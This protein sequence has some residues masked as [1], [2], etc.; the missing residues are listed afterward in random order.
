MSKGRVFITVVVLGLVV[1]FAS[2][3]LSQGLAAGTAEGQT[4]VAQDAGKSE[5]DAEPASLEPVGEDEVGVG[6]FSPEVI[7][8]GWQGRSSAESEHAAIQMEMQQ[9]Q[10]SGD[11]EVMMQAAMRMEQA[12]QNLMRGF[13]S[14]IEDAAPAV[15][16]EAG[17]DVVTGEIFYG[18][19]KVAE[20]DI[21]Q[22]LLARMNEAVEDDGDS[23]EKS[24]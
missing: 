5:P 8:Q 6:V 24:E 10:Q 16:R 20:R 23:G 21:S 2:V 14:A 1:A 17:L 15:A 7:W 13:L 9:A 3:S 4:A 19:G 11:Q 12:Q 18:G 22:Q